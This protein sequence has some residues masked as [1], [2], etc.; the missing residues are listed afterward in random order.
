MVGWAVGSA[1]KRLGPQARRSELIR[2]VAIYR[3]AVI[4]RH[5]MHG[6]FRP[7]QS[8]F[9]VASRVFRRVGSSTA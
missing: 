7:F 6:P 4:M 9:H 2:A 1:A 5:H 3:P 8:P